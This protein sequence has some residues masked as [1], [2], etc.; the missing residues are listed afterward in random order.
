[1]AP[2]DQELFTTPATGWQQGTNGS[3]KDRSRK[4]PVSPVLLAGIAGSVVVLI[5][6]LVVSLLFSGGRPPAAPDAVQA[7]TV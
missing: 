1:M 5:L 3:G 7:P 2:N 6:V 4:P